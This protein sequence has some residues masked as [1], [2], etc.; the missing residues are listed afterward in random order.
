MLTSNRRDSASNS[1][2][3]PLDF[4]RKVESLKVFLL[5]LRKRWDFSGFGRAVLDHVC[6]V[7]G[8]DYFD[9]VEWCDNEIRESLRKLEEG[10]NEKKNESESLSLP[11][12][13]NLRDPDSKV[14][15]I[16][17]ILW[18]P[19]EEN[20]D[21]N[22][23]QA[24][25]DLREEL[26][27]RL[28]ASAKGKSR[29]LLLELREKS[30]GGIGQDA[31][32][33]FVVFQKIML[34]AIEKLGAERGK[35]QLQVLYEDFDFSVGPL[36]EETVR[37]DVNVRTR[38]SGIEYNLLPSGLEDW[39]K[40]GEESETEP[41]RGCLATIWER[42]RRKTAKQTHKLANMAVLPQQLDTSDET[43]KTKR[44]SLGMKGRVGGSEL[45][46]YI[47]TEGEKDLMSVL[48][49][50]DP[51][52]PS[53]RSSRKTIQGCYGIAGNRGTGK[54][55]L[56]WKLA[57]E[58]KNMG[59]ES[60]I[61]R[62][63]IP[64]EFADREFLFAFLYKLCGV[65][66]KSL[67]KG[68][69]RKLT[70]P[71]VRAAVS[72]WHHKLLLFL[73]L[74]GVYL[75]KTDINTIIAHVKSLWE[76]LDQRVVL[77]SVLLG[78]CITLI[79]A[80]LEVSQWLYAHIP[81]MRRLSLYLFVNGI[82]ADLDNI[83]KVEQGGIGEY[84]WSLFSVATE[85]NPMRYSIPLL[86]QQ[87]EQVIDKLNKS[88]IFGRVV[89]LIDDLDKL[90]LSAA[91][92]ALKN[93]RRIAALSNCLMVISCPRD[94]YLQFAEPG[95]GKRESGTLFSYMFLLEDFSEN[96]TEVRE[97]VRSKLLSRWFGKELLE[98]VSQWVESRT[99]RPVLI[100]ELKK[101]SDERSEK[102]FWKDLGEQSDGEKSRDRKR[103]RW[104]RRE[105]VRIFREIFENWLDIRANLEGAY[106]EVWEQKSVPK[107]EEYAYRNLSEWERYLIAYERVHRGLSKQALQGEIRS[108]AS[109]K[110][111]E[112]FVKLLTA[113]KEDL[114]RAEDL[115][116]LSKVLI[117]LLQ[118]VAQTS[119][120]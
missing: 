25:K 88:R 67:C 44:D 53:V 103:F 56:L 33:D 55:T 50:I 74:A 49:R 107:Q 77:V 22:I 65:A 23:A 106:E 114:A 27:V 16:V 29:K 62:L 80:R 115:Q 3:C 5:L 57:V 119:E 116:E 113:K 54:S 117:A 37:F 70:A 40:S 19:E 87:I 14:D 101:S 71:I 15:G 108:F 60:L 92:A 110:A 32:K 18:G 112:P 96:G 12:L 102:Y 13:K 11:S 95:V 120:V 73:S 100:D 34:I 6:Y 1:D 99:N 61:V 46:S 69:F 31:L 24:R 98:V 83:R 118:S 28:F 38:S 41:R 7:R 45:S 75:L 42:V 20:G 39:Y 82:M 47:P 90:D 30:L 2:P 78:V 63:P 72:L 85:V 66:Q 111:I 86:S 105:V 35:S 36:P 97:Y 79:L 26:W 59:Q 94:I 17:Q 51:E 91:E 9:F 93:F 10:T 84:P 8:K 81:E 4:I 76:S 68:W 109:F 104:N 58:L 43:D 89:I 21:S 64:R 48:L 52:G